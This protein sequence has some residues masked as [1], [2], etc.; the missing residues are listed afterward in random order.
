MS[1]ILYETEFALHARDTDYTGAWRPSAIML[2]MQ[3][4][5][6]IH[7]QRLGAGFDEL[8][9]ANFAWVLSRSSVRMNRYPRIEQTVRLRT[10]PAKM[11]HLIYPR[12]FEF[13]TLEG[14]PLGCASTAWVILDMGERRMAADP[15]KVGIT[16]PEN[17][18][19][20]PPLPMPRVPR[21]L[22]AVPQVFSRRVVYE[23]VDVNGH[24]NNTRYID[25]L[26]DA[27]EYERFAQ[28]S[29]GSLNIAYESEIRPGEEV[30]LELARK[31]ES[32]SMSGRVGERACFALTGE[33]LRC[34]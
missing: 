32:F 12:Y 23:D 13:E 1:E 15:G 24:V 30:V 22:E 27:L 9:A 7:A 31:D 34:D 26:C 5:A 2:A 3:Q 17:E 16:V 18:L 28:G 29:L 33:F 10:W 20:K 4:A 6:E 14:E 25:W 11:R 8:R 21:M 19:R